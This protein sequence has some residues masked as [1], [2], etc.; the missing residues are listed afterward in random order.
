[1]WVRMRYEQQ[2]MLSAIYAIPELATQYKITTPISNTTSKY[3]R[4]YDGFVNSNRFGSYPEFIAL[5]KELD[6]ISMNSSN[7]LLLKKV[8]E[9][10]L[11]SVLDPISIISEYQANKGNKQ[12]LDKLLLVITTI[13]DN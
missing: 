8:S 13:L 9:S 5:K 2:Q 11:L 1:M 10:K 12:I 7:K 6:A 3:I 4:L